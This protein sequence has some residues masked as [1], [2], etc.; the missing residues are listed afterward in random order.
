[1]LQMELSDRLAAMRDLGHTP[2]AMRAAA[3]AE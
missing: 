2:A 3:E 1:V